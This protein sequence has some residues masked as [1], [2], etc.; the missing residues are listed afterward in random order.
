[1]LGLAR[2]RLGRGGGRYLLVVLG[3]AVAAAVLAGVDGAGLAAGDRSLG[4]AV[5]AIDQADRGVRVD[6]SGIPSQGAPSLG[7][8]DSEA[9]RALARLPGGRPARVLFFRESEI[10]G[11]LTDLAAIDD[12]GRW[13]RVRSGR[14]PRPCTPARCEVLQLAGAGPL[15]HLPGLHIVRVGRGSVTSRFPFG[16]LLSSSSQRSILTSSARYHQ[17]AQPPFLLADGVAGLASTRLLA[18]FQ[19]TYSWLLPLTASSVHPWTAD[20]FVTQTA[21]AQSDLDAQGQGFLLAAPT[22]QVAQA[23]ATARAGQR[24]LLLLGGAGAALLLGFVVLAAAAGRREAQ[25]SARRLGWLGGSRWQLFL[26][27]GTEAAAVA[28]LGVVLGW[29]AGTALAAGAAHRLGDAAGAVL[30]HSALSGGAAGLAVLLAAGAALVLVLTRRSPDLAFGGVSLTVLD[31]LALGALA[32]IVLGA[33]RGEADASALARDGGTGVFLLLLPGLVVFVAAVAAARLLYPMLRLLERLARRASLPV[34]LAATSLA[35]SPGRAA[36]VVSF[37]VA[38]FALALF[39]SAYRST[40]AQGQADEA[41]Y[42]VPRDAVARESL[43][44][45]VPVSAAASPSAYRRRGDAAPVLRQSGDVSGLTTSQGF[46]LLGIPPGILPGLD[47]WRS[48]FS[49]LS[50]AELARRIA[51]RPSAMRGVRLPAKARTLEVPAAVNGTP[52]DVKATVMSPRRLFTTLDLGT[53]R[54]STTLRAPLPPALRGGLLVRLSFL[55]AGG[56]PIGT[57]AGL[58]AQPRTE[59]TLRLGAFRAGGQTLATDYAEWTGGQGVR[60]TGSTVRYLLTP[61]SGIAIGVFRPR[62]PTD[63]RA[64]PAV[65]SPALA[66]AAGRHGLLPTMVEGEPLLLRVTGIA[67]RFPTVQGDVVVMDRTAVSTALNATA[68]GTGVTNELWIDARPGSSPQA[69]ARAL[70]RP[71]FASLDVSTRRGTLSRLRADPLGRGAVLVLGSAALAALALALAG[72]LLALVSDLRDERGELHDL[73]SQGAEPRALLR[74]LRLR[75]LISICFGVVGGLVAGTI[76]SALAV[77]LIRLTAGAG[78]PLP[79][80]RL[81]VDWPLVGIALAA[82]LVAALLPAFALTRARFR[83]AS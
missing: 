51:A 30:D 48:D 27:D 1:M 69:L 40:L 82:F 52:L 34:R 79:P 47:G 13:A 23:A 15:P 25:A 14:L 4:R 81:A 61:D 73:E 57:N 12:L 28:A 45:L 9:Q 31:A 63:G 70:R 16:P 76:L 77:S 39:A 71:P 74:H 2:R 19:R 55:R 5:L 36:I 22:E 37:L 53:V 17:P 59:G 44:D 32:A 20:A 75:F 67:S 33:L 11:A 18:D 80:L 35:R 29:A 41:A 10:G 78:E 83:E 66:A 24:R 60:A 46:T 56:L 54:G 26:L 7:A 43:D 38:S 64:L 6:W 8:L 21:Q 65:V 68:P 62:Q 58:G 3:I 50:R 72:V 42:A 49:A